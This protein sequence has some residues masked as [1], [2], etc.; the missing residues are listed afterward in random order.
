MDV[1]VS[2]LHIILLC[3]AAMTAGLVD[4]IAGGGGLITL[5][6]LLAA[7]LPPHVALGTNKGQ[8]VFGTFAALV[9]F[10]RAGLVDGKL[11]RV[12]FPF[13]LAG[14]LAGAALVLLVKPEVLKPLV[15][16]LLIAVAVFLTFRKAPRPGDAPEPGPRPRAQAIGA[17]IALGLGTYDGF[18]GPGTGTFLI[19]A[20]STLLGHGL[21]RASADA[22]VVN[23]ASNLAS[24]T[25][26]A[27][28]GVVLWKVALPMAAAQ[29]SGAYVGAHLAVKGGDKL[30]RRVVLGVVLA[31]V[32]KLGRDV[33]MG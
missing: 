6:A 23:F 20:F 7:G 2:T 12:T 25:M 19:V 8:S 22:K 31:L 11:A 10:S 16:V 1:D 14:A 15:L 30:V 18:F 3:L 9:R 13:G 26:F 24:M 21:A 33:V 27:L 28:K 29:F 5:P 4:A 32:L 17:L